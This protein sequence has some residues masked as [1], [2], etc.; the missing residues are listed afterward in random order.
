MSVPRCLGI[1]LFFNDDDLVSDA[2][3]HL[4]ENNHEIVVWDHGST[5]G[6]ADE[7]SKFKSHIRERHF[8]PRSF[9]FYQLF[10]HVS[11]YVIENYAPQYDWISFPE[12]D[13]FLEGPD[14]K[15]KYFEHIC[16]VYKSPYDWLQFNNIVYWFTSND[17]VSELSPRK[18]IRRYSIWPNCGPRIY[19][20]R[21]ECMNVR[22]F[23]HNPAL[24]V[25]YPVLFNTC[26]YQFRSAAQMVK[27][28]EGRMGLSRAKANYHF[29]FMSNNMKKLIISPE[30]LNYDDKL[31]EL[32]LV[33]TLD[34]GEVYGTYDQLF[35]KN[36]NNSK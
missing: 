10:E 24:G 33:P 8:L 9:D 23:N 18:R 14:R 25:K 2:I 28:I 34:W 22:S 5:D 16:D 36:N 20:W 27:R 26:H 19:A 11:R 6:T 13:E 15:K 21:A 31:N 4:L 17:L 29:D 12:S 32:S 30:Q 7:I 1:C 3:T 35:A